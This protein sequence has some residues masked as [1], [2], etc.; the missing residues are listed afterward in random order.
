MG[1]IVLKQ[2]HEIYSVSFL[3]LLSASSVPHLSND[4][5]LSIPDPMDG[6]IR[7][8][9]RDLFYLEVLVSEVF[10]D[11]QRRSDTRIHSTPYTVPL[12]YTECSP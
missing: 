9:A 6:V 8:A 1:R 10:S 5:N 4:P 11:P 2:L 3:L 12:L 7:S